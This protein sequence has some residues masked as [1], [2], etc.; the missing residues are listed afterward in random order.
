[1]GGLK[2]RIITAIIIAAVICIE[3]LKTK[4]KITLLTCLLEIYL[5]DNT[6]SVQDFYLSIFD[7]GFVN[8]A[9]HI[10]LAILFELF[11]CKNIDFCHSW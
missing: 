5:A 3:M 6:F 7:A 8:R 11:Q 1:M 2:D 9:V 4:V 10:L